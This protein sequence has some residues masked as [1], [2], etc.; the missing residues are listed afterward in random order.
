MDHNL[1]P[2]QKKCAIAN[3]F[4][5]IKDFQNIVMITRRVYNW[6]VVDNETCKGPF[7]K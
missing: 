3:P 1:D 2:D 6:F 5:V 7:V 4:I